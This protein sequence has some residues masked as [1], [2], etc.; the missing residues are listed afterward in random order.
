MKTKEEKRIERRRRGVWYKRFR[1]LGNVIE[2]GATTPD[3]LREVYR[4]LNSSAKFGSETMANQVDEILEQ[5][6][7]DS[8]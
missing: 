5:L 3:I 7:T 2:E 4:L 6:I 8:F 1:Q